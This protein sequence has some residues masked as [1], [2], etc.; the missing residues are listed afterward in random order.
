MAGIDKEVGYRFLR[1]RYVQLRRGG[2]SAGDAVDAL[3][4]RSSRLPDWEALVGRDGRHHLRV[5]PSREQVFWAAFEGG[6]DCDAACRAVGVARSTGYRWIQRRFGELRSSGVSLTRSIRVLRLTPRRAEAFERERQA[7]EHRKRNAATAAHRDALHASAGLVDA[8][9][10]ET[11][12]T[13]RRR[14]R[15]DRYW[16]LMREGVSNVD[17]CR[18]LGMSRPVGT[19]I[20][21]QN[22]F[23]IPSL[24][25]PRP[26]SGRYLTGRERVQIADLLRLGCSMRQI[27][28]QL[29]RHPSTISREL[30]RHTDAAGNYLP[31]TADLDA[32]RQRARP[33]TP[34]LVANLPLRL[35]VQRKLNRCW[36]PEE[37]AGWLRKTYPG[38][39]SMHVC[40]ETIYRALLL[41]EPG[42]LHQRYAMKLRTGRRIRKTRWRTRTGQGSRI[43]NM[44]MIDQRPAEIETK[45]VAGHWEGDLIVG[46]GSVSAMVT[47]RERKTQYG[48]VINLPKDHTAASVNH[49]VIGAFATLPAHL[50][51]SLT[52]DQGVEM[53]SHEALTAATGIPIYFA[54]RASPWQ[55]GANENFNGLLRQYFPKGTNLAQH[56]T[57][58]VARVV[59]EINHRPRKTLDYD[60]PARRLKHEHR[61]PQ[62]ALR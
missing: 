8:M 27:G 34:R 61:T 28:R 4:F 2:L 55:R 7:T 53:S 17:A 36:S 59:N 48:M 6:A 38:E 57:A 22:N 10:G 19:R 58:H 1:D 47:L 13:R 62:P 14:E 49:A 45:Q 43:R 35:L 9:L 52:W 24:T 12:A 21:K 26:S 18:I 37:I 16:Q 42:G 51:R 33:K 3:G 5:D 44:T 60:T 11:D 54:E 46:V 41:R 39:P 31:G 56:S 20:R 23:L 29:G 30:R 25:P 15:A 50:K 40:H 32:H